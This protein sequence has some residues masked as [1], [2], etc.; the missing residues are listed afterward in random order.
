MGHLIIDTDDN[1]C[2]QGRPSLVKAGI[3]QH[4]Y[5]YIYI[6]IDP[7]LKNINLT[8]RNYPQFIGTT[9]HVTCRC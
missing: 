1:A 3:F 9:Q 6:F 4:I 5:I 2:E 8:Y 7:N